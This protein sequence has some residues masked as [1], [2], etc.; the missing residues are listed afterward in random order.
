MGEAIRNIYGRKSVEKDIPGFLR[1]Q[2]IL[3]NQLVELSEFKMMN[4]TTDKNTNPP[5]KIGVCERF[6]VI[7]INLRLF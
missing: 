4:S 1:K 5:V 3:L 6:V 2:N 7:L